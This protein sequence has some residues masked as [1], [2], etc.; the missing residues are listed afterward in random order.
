VG[1]SELMKAA[2]LLARCTQAG[3]GGADFPTVWHT[4]LKGHPLVAGI[5]SQRLD[6]ARVLLDIPLITRQTLIYDGDCRRYT[7]V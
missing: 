1:H 6:G 4:V 7:L 2:S 5:P 3:D